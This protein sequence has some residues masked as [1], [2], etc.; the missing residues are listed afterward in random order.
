VTAVFWG[1][2]LLGEVVTVPIIAGMI[3][4][5]A[6]IVLTNVGRGKARASTDKAA[7]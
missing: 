2:T 5:L 7:A 4:I 1:A 6:G 3:V